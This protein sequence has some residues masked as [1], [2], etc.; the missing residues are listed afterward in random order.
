MKI[1]VLILNYALIALIAIVILSASTQPD[2]ASSTI[3]GCFIFLPAPILAVI[4]A[5][6]GGK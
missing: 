4:Y 6:R 5:H 3:V 1:A 2:T